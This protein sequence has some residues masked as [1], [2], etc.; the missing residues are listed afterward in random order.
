MVNRVDRS[1]K[2]LYRTVSLPNVVGAP[3]IGRW[4]IPIDFLQLQ[5]E[6]V[7]ELPEGVV[8]IDYRCLAQSCF[9]L[10]AVMKV[11]LITKYCKLSR[12]CAFHTAFNKMLRTPEITTLG[13]PF[14]QLSCMY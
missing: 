3:L 10:P 1:D 9:I 7:A 14:N 12:I 8:Y 4:E 13:T 5:I 6:S 2:I 11:I